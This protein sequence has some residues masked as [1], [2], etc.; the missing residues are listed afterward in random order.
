MDFT[1][2]QYE[3]WK[4]ETELIEEQLARIERA[5]RAILEELGCPT[6]LVA[7]YAI[8]AGESPTPWL[9][10]NAP[11]D[12]RRAQHAMYA[13]LYVQKTRQYLSFSNSIRPARRMPP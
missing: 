11:R 1:R 10:R 9:Q 8:L 5:E 6:D 2:D 13:L 12:E 7:V 4:L 3:R